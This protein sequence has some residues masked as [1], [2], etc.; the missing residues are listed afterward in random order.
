MSSGLREYDGDAKVS[1]G[2]LASGAST[3]A[4]IFLIHL[5]TEEVKVFCTVLD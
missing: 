2:Y 3:I 5:I 1:D 4:E